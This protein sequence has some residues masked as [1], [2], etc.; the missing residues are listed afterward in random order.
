MGLRMRLK[1]HRIHTCGQLLAAVGKREARTVLA[2][3][4]GIDPED[5]DLL[6]ARA[7]LARVHGLGVVFAQMLVALG[8]RDVTRLAGCDPVTLHAD[9]RRYNREEGLARRSPTP[10]EVADWVAQARALPP[11]VT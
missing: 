10:E 5:L 7:D 3:A 4:A 8:V 9:L 1:S 2:D 11:A 6:V